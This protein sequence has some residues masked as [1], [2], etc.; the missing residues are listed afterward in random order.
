MKQRRVDEVARAVAVALAVSADDRLGALVAP[1]LDVGHHALVLLLRD[2]RTELRGLVESRPHA[3]ALGGL[4]QRRDDV[5][6]LVPV[7]EQPR[8]GVAGLAG[9]EVDAHEGALDRRFEVGVGEDDVRA[10]AAQLE[11]HALEHP[12]GLRPDLAADGG[13]AGEGDLRRSP[14]ARPARRR[15][16]RSPVST[17]TTPW[18]EPGLLDQLSQ[19]Q[20]GQRRLLGR[21]QDH[22]AAGGERRG[23]LP[24]R[25]QEREVPRDDLAADADRLLE[26]VDERVR[27]ADR[28]RLALDLRRPA[29]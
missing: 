25:H 22:R 10:L 2:D 1:G 21:L 27:P 15:C 13:R 9:V 20:R 7:H 8:A 19:P 4:G 23:D 3:R 26:R 17:F 11:R 5:V 16:R 18:R 24:R 6:V 12:P 29:A 28:D 14:G